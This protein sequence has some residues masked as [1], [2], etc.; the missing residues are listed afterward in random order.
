[1]V[2]ATTWLSRSCIIWATT[3]GK[4][5]L[6]KLNIY[7]QGRLVRYKVNL[8]LKILQRA[9]KVVQKYDIGGYS[10]NHT[11]ALAPLKGPDEILHESTK[12]DKTTT[13]KS[14]HILRGEL[15]LTLNIIF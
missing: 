1:M 12:Y 4:G 14:L 8:I 3:I 6:R 5:V 15:P 2:L 7:S 11:I 10:T 13:K 9:R